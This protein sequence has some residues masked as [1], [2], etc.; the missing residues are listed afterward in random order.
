MSRFAH[1]LQAAV[2]KQPPTEPEGT[3]THGSQITQANTGPYAYFDTTLGRTL[4]PGDL[5]ISSAARASDLTTP[6]G[7]IRKLHLTASD[8]NIDIDCTL[9]ACYLDSSLHSQSGATWT[10]NWCTADC[11]S[12][13]QWQSTD[14]SVWGGRW[15]IY[16]CQAFGA[17]DAM[18]GSSSDSCTESWIRTYGR[19]SDSHNDAYQYYNPSA[20]PS[21]VTSILRSNLDCRPT[22]GI[23]NPNAALFAADSTTMGTFYWRDNLLRGGAIVVRCNDSG[24]Y[25]VTG[26]KIVDDDASPAGQYGAAVIAE[27]SGNVLVDAVGN[28]LGTVAA[29]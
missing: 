16:R 23:G 1:R 14:N 18:R 21:D 5:T 4:T 20:S 15:T 17:A 29:P 2:S 26:N 28:T 3:V 19:A 10:A 27:W 12:A 24:S 6:G 25:H 8:F 9:E 13:T 7:T 22:N 11:T